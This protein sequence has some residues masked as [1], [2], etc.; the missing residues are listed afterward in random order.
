M[1]NEE[2]SWSIEVDPDEELV[3]KKKKPRRFLQGTFL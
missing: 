2:D 3:E 1:A